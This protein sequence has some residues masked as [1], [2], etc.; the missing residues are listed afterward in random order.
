MKGTEFAAY[1]RK[2][3]R[4]NSTSLTD[5]SIV[6]YA[7]A[8]KDTVAM[9]IE[10]VGTGLFD[11]PAYTSLVADQREYPF[12]DD[13]LS[14]MKIVRAKLDGTN[15]K[16][17]SEFDLNAYRET[18]TSPVFP[19]NAS[20]VNSA[21][22]D[23]TTDES[24]I[25]E[26][27]SDDTP[28]FEITRNSIKIYTESAITAVS[29]GLWLIYSVYPADIDTD[30]L[31]SDTQLSTDPTTTTYGIPRQFHKYWAMRVIISYKEDNDIPLDQFDLAVQQELETAKRAIAQPNEDRTITPTVPRDTGFQY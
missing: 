23:A 9:E 27:F 18:Q 20:D 3:T 28:Q 31:A 22:S 1:I 6:V 8:E 5:A 19:Y 7:N 11:M 21:F 16:R 10:S 30:T 13:I 24:T 2:R 29:E 26:L 4:T 25:Q 12:P 17:L 14:R 15:W